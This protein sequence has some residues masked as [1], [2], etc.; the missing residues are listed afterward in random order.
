M[1]DTIKVFVGTV[2]ETWLPFKV[3]EYSILSRTTSPCDV[4]ELCRWDYMIPDRW[5]RKAATGFSFQRFLIP[6]ICEHQGRGIYLDSDM[7]LRSDIRELWETPFPAGKQIL[8]TDS[9]QTAVILYDCTIP[10]TVKGII[11]RLESGSLRMNAAM[12]MD[13][14][15]E[16]GRT[17]DRMWNCTDRP[18]LEKINRPDAKLLHF[19]QINPTTQPWI[20]SGHPCG[21]IWECELVNAISAGFLT[22]AEVREEIILEHVRPSLSSFIGE[23]SRE[24]DEEWF[25]RQKPNRKE[26]Y[27]YPK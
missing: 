1:E 27:R 9:W 11:E 2:R 6:E 22:V 20:Y 8:K 25:S 16:T 10:L 5:K 19:T 15:P 14:F 4:Q 3:L 26:F 12:N 23:K 24:T 13:K 17:I 21:N 18:K 7:L